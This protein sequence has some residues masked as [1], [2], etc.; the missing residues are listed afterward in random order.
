MRDISVEKI[1]ET[2]ARLCQQANF[3]LP[4]DVWQALEQAFLKERSETGREILS[5][6]LENARISAKKEIALCQDTGIAEIFVKLGQDVHIQG[7]AL[8]TL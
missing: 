5:Q 1:T 6:V 8:L 3:F 7:E 4:K 2:V